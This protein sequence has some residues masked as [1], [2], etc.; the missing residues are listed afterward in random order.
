MG[1]LLLVRAPGYLQPPGGRLEAC[2]PEQF[3]SIEDATTFCRRFFSWCNPDHRHSGLGPMIPAMVHGG[4]VEAVTQV[5]KLTS[6]AAFEAQ[7]ERFVQ[8][9]PRP[10]VGAGGVLDQ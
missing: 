10:A 4:E 2:R 5:G 8:R 9:T 6:S 3:G 7:P 1:L